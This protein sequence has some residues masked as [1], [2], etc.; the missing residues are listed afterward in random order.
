M[1]AAARPAAPLGVLLV[2]GNG[3]VGGMETSVLRLVRALP[4]DGYRM[5]AV[6]PF[7]GALVDAMREAGVEVMAM[8]V[9]ADPA[10]HT[11]LAAVALVR[12]LR[13]AVVHAH[14]PKAHALAAL[15]GPVAR[16]PVLA[17]VHGMHLTVADVEAHRLSGSTICV[18][19]EAARR[20]AM[21][22]GVARDRLRL[23]RNA[24]DTE[25]FAPAPFGARED[26]FGFGP[27]VAVVGY[28][29]RLSEE[30]HPR[31]FVRAAARVR[32]ARPDVRF[33]MVGDG[34]LRPALEA[35]AR[36]LGLDNRVRF[37]GE[38]HDT[39]AVHRSLDVLLLTSWHEGTPLAVLEAMAC[40]V[41]VVASDVGGVPELVRSG[42][43]GLLFGAGDE[44][45]A[46]AHVLAL[47]QDEEGRRRMG[48]AGRVRAVTEFAWPEHVA[49]VTALWR[50]HA[51]RGRAGVPAIRAASGE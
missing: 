44:A 43:T 40:G 35:E 6:V 48:R 13:L 49:A 31:L 9:T 23:L 7:E 19:S 14:L 32:E 4:R 26:V 22:A 51:E 28:V 37:A 10:W 34:P 25:A 24:I 45:A 27:G 5:A 8:P 21:A 38:R 46:A 47:L 39:P 50:E 20:H 18:V 16:V 12:Q 29:G 41:P 1:S 42:T 30:K 11:L 2:L 3:I 33:V 15:I 17:T 36:E